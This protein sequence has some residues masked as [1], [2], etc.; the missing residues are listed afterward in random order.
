MA[1]ELFNGPMMHGKLRDANNR[2]RTSLANGKSL[3]EIIQELYM[4]GLCRPPSAIEIQTASAHCASASEPSIGL[5]D[6]CWALFNTDEFLF[7]H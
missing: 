4:A 1:I 3:V 2:F 5:E 6:V 7:Q